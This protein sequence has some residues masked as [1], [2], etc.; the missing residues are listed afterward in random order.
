MEKLILSANE[1]AVEEKAN[2]GSIDSD[3]SRV[4]LTCMDG[5]VDL[6]NDFGPNE[7]AEKFNIH[8]LGSAGCQLL[9]GD[10][11]DEEIRDYFGKLL[12]NA[13][14]RNQILTFELESH[15][16]APEDPEHGCG[17]HGSDTV[18]ALKTTYNLAIRLQKLFPQANVYR[19]HRYTNSSD[20]K[21]VLTSVLSEGSD[22]PADQ[23]Q[24]DPPKFS[25]TLLNNTLGIERDEHQET[26]LSF[27]QVPHA[28]PRIGFNSL[29]CSYPVKKEELEKLIDLGIGIIF[30]NGMKD[31]KTSEKPAVLHFDS[32]YGTYNHASFE[33]AR[34]ALEEVKEL[35]KSRRIEIGK[36]MGVT[37]GDLIDDGHLELLWTVTDDNSLKTKKVVV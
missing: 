8:W 37:L 14:T 25:E 6:D 20:G 27:T 19:I 17:A 21:I 4:R 3:T 24:F 2:S 22:L 34:L 12:R 29:Q 30:T 1:H 18:A 5:R 16:H 26:V 9:N 15:S 28:F 32:A 35:L 36:L 33:E 13:E 7:N 11:T 31:Y 10:P 23:T